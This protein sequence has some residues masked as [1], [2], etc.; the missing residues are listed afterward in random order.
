MWERLR[1]SEA[2]T[3]ILLAALVGGLTGLGAVA[4]RKVLIDGFGW[5]FFDRG[6]V[7]LDFLGDNY[8]VILPI[9]GALLFG[10]LI[11]FL[12]REAPR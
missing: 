6:A 8:V 11:Y 4:F 1:G 12:C 9:V 7:V 2:T 5:I 3:G 10:P